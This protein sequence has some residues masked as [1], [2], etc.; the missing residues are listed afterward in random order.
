MLQKKLSAQ[1]KM[2]VMT[3]QRLLKYTPVCEWEYTVPQYGGL[4]FAFVLC[5]V[6]DS[7]PYQL[8]AQ[9][10]EY[11]VMGSNPTQGSSSSFQKKELSWV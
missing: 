2:K 6:V 1:S 9:L 3:V 5:C 11:S 8:V 10:V 4:R 7:N